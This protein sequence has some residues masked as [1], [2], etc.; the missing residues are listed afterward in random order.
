MASELPRIAKGASM[1]PNYRSAYCTASNGGG[2]LKTVYAPRSAT[3]EDDCIVINKQG[4][5]RILVALDGTSSEEV[6][7]AR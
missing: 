2:N 6:A 1:D 3:Q 7:R 4:T 5:H